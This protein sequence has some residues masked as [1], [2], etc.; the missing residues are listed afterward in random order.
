MSDNP[1]QPVRSWRRC[2]ARLVVFAALMYL[3]V[4]VVLLM[5]ENWLVYHP[6]GLDNWQPPPSPQIQDVDL[7]TADG[8]KIHGWWLP[9]ADTQQALIFF[10]GNAG[11]LSWRG[12]ALVALRDLLGVSVLSVDYPGYGKSGGKPTE[13]G[14]YA[15]ADAG[16]AWLTE[17]EKI[18][19]E[20]ILIF[21]ESLGGGVAVDLASRR[22]H[23]ALILDRTF[24]SVP[25]VG[26]TV[27]P[28]LPVHWLM[29]NRFDSLS[30]LDKCR[31]PIFI[32]HGTADQVV[33]FGHGEKLFQAAHEP[34]H[35]M[36]IEGGE[37]GTPLAP[38]FFT[39]LKAFL[40][41]VAVAAK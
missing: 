9:C 26:Q 8:T 41:G 17:T 3:G 23:R 21:G 31:Q 38:A 18:P 10:H 14:C 39:E 20:Q 24:T 7:A 28:C 6:S 4:I 36:R 34:K 33:P 25:D 40:D 32:A 5:L 19:G 29:R 2:L 16:Y 27:Y 30:K 11:N 37:H 35:F 1:A 12:D 22:P 15:A 13:A